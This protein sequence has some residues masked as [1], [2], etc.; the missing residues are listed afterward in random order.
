MSKMSLKELRESQGRPTPEPISPK[1][2]AL[3]DKY[4]PLLAPILRRPQPNPPSPQEKP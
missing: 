1:F 2:Q 3:C 4:R